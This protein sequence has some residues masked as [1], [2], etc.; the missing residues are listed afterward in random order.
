MIPDLSG[1]QFLSEFRKTYRKGIL[2]RCA[3]NYYAAVVPHWQDCEPH[4]IACVYK[5][6]DTTRIEL[7]VQSKPMFEY[8]G[9]A[10]QWA[11]NQALDQNSQ[12]T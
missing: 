8:E 5:R 4:W 7:T 9:P 11:I 3:T 12:E 1:V 6:S 10:L 2:V